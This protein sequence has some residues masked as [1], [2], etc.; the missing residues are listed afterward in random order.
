MLAQAASVIVGGGIAWRSWRCFDTACEVVDDLMLPSKAAAEM[1]VEA[2]AAEGVNVARG[3]R[4]L[5]GLALQCG[6][7]LLLVYVTMWIWIRVRRPTRGE[8]AIAGRGP[9]GTHAIAGDGPSAVLV[10]E[11]DQSPLAVV[12]ECS[13]CFDSTVV[14]SARFWIQSFSSANAG[15]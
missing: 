5:I 1:V 11:P 15:R 13:S 3:V 8:L 9:E 14:Q 12:A 6:L 4:E 10:A 2:V 7:T